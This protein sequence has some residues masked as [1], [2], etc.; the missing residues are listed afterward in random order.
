MTDAMFAH[1]TITHA[2]FV[3]KDEEKTELSGMIDREKGF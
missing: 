3:P 2:A 1:I